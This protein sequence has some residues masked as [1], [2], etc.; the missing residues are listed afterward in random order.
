[1]FKFSSKSLDLQQKL[2]SFMDK[3]VYPNELA[4]HKEIA[5]DENL[6]ENNEISLEELKNQEELEEKS[7]ESDNSETSQNN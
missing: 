1:M 4:I 3:Y 7:N 5:K 2:L 6:A